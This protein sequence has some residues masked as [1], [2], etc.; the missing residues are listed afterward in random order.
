MS[1][2]VSRV[3]QRGMTESVQWALIWPLLLLVT[4]GV[5][6]AGLWVHGRQSALRAAA[7][8]ADV[9]SGRDGSA[10]AAEDLAASIARSAG[11]TSVEVD[12][13]TSATQVRV[14]V[15]GQ[16]PTIIEL[17]LG[18]IRESAAAPRERVTTP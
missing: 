16:I 18:H 6:Q 7:A 3:D 4:L 14:L 8:A 12:V 15:S 9:A 2:T 5:I 11:L 1:R 17:P 13:Q 10:G